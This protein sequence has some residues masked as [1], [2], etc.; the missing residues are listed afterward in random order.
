[1][2]AFL[3]FGITV[4]TLRYDRIHPPGNFTLHDLL[5]ILPIV[6]PVLVVRATGAQL[7]EALENG[8]YKYPALDGRYVHMLLLSYV[9]NFTMGLYKDKFKNGLTI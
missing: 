2:K 9:L 1:M 5:A 7:L 8:V 3:P 4:G 6:D